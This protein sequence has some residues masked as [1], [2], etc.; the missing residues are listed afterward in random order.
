MLH[1]YAREAGGMWAGNFVA[2][3]EWRRRKKLREL[4]GRIDRAVEQTERDR[5]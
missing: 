1:R 2:L 3:W 5:I 4:R